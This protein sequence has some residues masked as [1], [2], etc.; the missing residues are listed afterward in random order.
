MSVRREKKSDVL[1]PKKIGSFTARAWRQK[2]RR[3]MTLMPRRGGQD[4]GLEVEWIS[5]W[6]SQAKSG[7]PILTRGQGT[8]LLI[9]R[10]RD[11]KHSQ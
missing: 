5:A 6:L 2:F 11:R 1:D 8:V 9:S 4:Q 10:I 3:E 7:L